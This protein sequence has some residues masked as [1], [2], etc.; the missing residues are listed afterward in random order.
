MTRYL[1]ITEFARDNNIPRPT[2]KSWCQKGQLAGAYK[3]GTQYNIPAGAPIPLLP[4]GRPRKAQPVTDPAA[5]A[6][7]ASL[8]VPAPDEFGD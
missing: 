8:D 1:S 7:V 3:V 6:A 4:R 5:R 2:V